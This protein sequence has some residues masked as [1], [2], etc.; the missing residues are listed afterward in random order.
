MH[1]PNTICTECGWLVCRC[2]DRLADCDANDEG[3]AS[4]S[5]PDCGG[6]LDGEFGCTDLQCE[7]G[8]IQ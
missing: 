7:I 3:D 5:C 4:T 2:D 1:D 6:E 8:H